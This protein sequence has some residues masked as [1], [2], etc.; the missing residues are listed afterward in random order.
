MSVAKILARLSAAFSVS[1]VQPAA[2]RFGRDGGEAGGAGAAGASRG[3]SRAVLYGYPGQ[4]RNA[5]C[6]FQCGKIDDY[7]GRS[8][9]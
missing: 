4:T 9:C 2:P 1:A 6:F 8:R 5:K 3:F 7:S